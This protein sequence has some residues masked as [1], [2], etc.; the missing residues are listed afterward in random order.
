MNLY[1]FQK[2]EFKSPF[3]GTC[4]GILVGVN[5]TGVKW[6]I[7]LSNSKDTV[8]WIDNKDIVGLVNSDYKENFNLFKAYLMESCDYDE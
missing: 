6:E 8:A 7:F 3:G 1:P 4:L 5:N 2:V